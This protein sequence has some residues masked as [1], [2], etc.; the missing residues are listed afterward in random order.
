MV[1][2]AVTWDAKADPNRTVA[3]IRWPLLAVGLLTAVY[4]VVGV[5]LWGRTL[6]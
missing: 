6:G 4:Q 5:A 1:V 3:S 2:F